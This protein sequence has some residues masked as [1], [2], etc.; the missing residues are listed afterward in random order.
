MHVSLIAA[1]ANN[2][3]IGYQGDMPWHLPAELRYFKELTLGKPIVMGRKTFASIGR[4]LPG[5]TNIVLT[6]QAA[7]LPEGVIAVSSVDDALAQAKAVA[8]DDGEV[9]IIG[10]GEIYNAFLPQATR[11]YL[12]HI[13][14]ETKGD[15]W[16]PEW[17]DEQWQKTLLRESA[18]TADNPLAFKGYLYERL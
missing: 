16:F 10:G 8:G 15:T 13:D 6:R 2:R 3:V 17:R 18:A 1:M 12:T 7:D 11:L 9:M 4:A 14:L 5:R